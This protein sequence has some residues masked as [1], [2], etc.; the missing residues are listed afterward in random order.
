M[1]ELIDKCPVHLHKSDTKRRVIMDPALKQKR[2]A[3]Y[4]IDRPM[5]KVKRGIKVANL[6]GNATPGN[7]GDTP[8]NEM[9]QV[10]G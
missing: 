5:P 9:P 6:I 4:G 10:N 2:I 3:I 8:K 7:D 1:Y